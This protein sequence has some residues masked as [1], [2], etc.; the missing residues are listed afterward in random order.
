MDET[1]RPEEVSEKVK[2]QTAEIKENVS[3]AVEQARRS[4]ETLWDEAKRK[5][6]GLQSLEAYVREKPTQAIMITVGI[7]FLLG[8]LWRK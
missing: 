3:A 8:L 5:L 4:A 7:G 6:S 1:T 2:D